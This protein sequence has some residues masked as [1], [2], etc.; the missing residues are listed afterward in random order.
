[1]EYWGEEAFASLQLYSNFDFS[2]LLDCSIVP[3]FHYSIIPR[4]CLIFAIDSSQIV[5][6]DFVSA[7]AIKQEFG[8]PPKSLDGIFAAEGISAVDP[9][10][11]LNSIHAHLSGM[12]FRQHT[13]VGARDVALNHPGTPVEEGPRSFI[14]GP[15]F[16]KF[17]PDQL[18]RAD[19]FSKGDPVIGILSCIHH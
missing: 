17:F 4:S 19:G 10:R 6:Q 9:H 7:A 1:M 3:S 16:G 18:V 8:I 15:V 11:L 14:P 5:T 13:F 2:S 12:I